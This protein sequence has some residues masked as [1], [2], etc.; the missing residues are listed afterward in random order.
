M[1]LIQKISPVGVDAL[2]DNIQEEFYNAISWT[3]AS[4]GYESYHRAYKNE[5][6]LG[7]IPEVY[8]SNDDY[9]EVF[10][11]DQFSATSFFL[12]DDRRS[13]TDGL[14]SVKINIIF[15]V[16]LD[17]IYP[18]ITH[19]ADEEA[20]NDALT[21]LQSMYW[22]FKTTDLEVGVDNVYKKLAFNDKDCDDM[23]PYHVFM[24]S[25]ESNLQLQCDPN[26]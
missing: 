20:H 26:C 11:D 25:L 1:A 24:I 7:K 5:S 18:S 3:S 15:Q 14:Q 8:T 13:L 10:M 12:V 23:H 16:L 2:I 4:N 21:L 22:D 9:K 17:E 19:R 6:N